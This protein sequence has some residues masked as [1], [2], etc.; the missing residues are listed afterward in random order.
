MGK[1]KSVK[2][3]VWRHPT[4]G[5]LPLMELPVPVERMISGRDETLTYTIEDIEDFLKQKEQKG[6]DIGIPRTN[7]TMFHS[8]CD[9]VVSRKTL[10]EVRETTLRR[11]PSRSSIKKCRNYIREF[12]KFQLKKDFPNSDLWRKYHDYFDVP[13]PPAKRGM[14]DR[15]IKTDDIRE[16]LSRLD[17]LGDIHGKTFVMFGALTG[18]RVGVLPRLS[19]EQIQKGIRDGSI[20]VKPE[21]DKVKH[22]CVFCKNH[23]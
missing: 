8:V 11:Y 6:V 17:T 14:S 10:D 20:W 19:R 3:V 21:Q 18:Q 13:L 23:W 7:L 9:G 15:T 5:N 22:L 12:L 4:Y 16:V 2:K 1:K